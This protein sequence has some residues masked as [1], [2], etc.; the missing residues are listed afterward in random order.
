MGWRLALDEIV[1]FRTRL[2]DGEVHV[3]GF[4]GPGSAALG[5]VAEFDWALQVADP[6]DAYTGPG[7][8]TYPGHALPAARAALAA[9]GLTRP[10]IVVRMPAPAGERYERVVEDEDPQGWEPVSLEW[11][12]ARVPGAPVAAFPRGGYIRRAIVA[13]S[14]PH[15]AP[16]PR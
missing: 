5:L 13:G 11:L 9:A 12:R 6:A 2:A 4:A 3:R 1:P 10:E 7:I 8:W 14:P 16:A 15:G